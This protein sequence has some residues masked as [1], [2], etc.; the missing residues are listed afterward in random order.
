MGVSKV[1]GLPEPRPVGPN[2]TFAFRYPAPCLVQLRS[3]LWSPF[4]WA[5]IFVC[6][7]CVQGGVAA[8]QD[9]IDHTDP[10]TTAIPDFSIDS[11][12]VVG[13]SFSL[14]DRLEYGKTTSDVVHLVNKADCSVYNME[15]TA[16]GADGVNSDGA[17]CGISSS[18]TPT[19]TVRWSGNPD[20]FYTVWSAKIGSCSKEKVGT[21]TNTCTLLTDVESLG[22]KPY[23]FDVPLAVILGTARLEDGITG[24]RE[25]CSSVTPLVDS[26]NLYI[27]V[28]ESESNDVDVVTVP[29]EF[30]Y[31]YD[32]PKVP[33][34]V[35]VVA[36]G[37]TIDVSWTKLSDEEDDI[38]YQIYYS[39]QPFSDRSEVP[40]GNVVTVSGAKSSATLQD[41]E[42]G[43]EYYVSVGAKD[44]FDNLGE[45]SANAVATPI[46][47][48]DGFEAYKDAGG[49]EDGG[50]CF[51]ATAAY[52]SY[53]HP[54]VAILRDFRDTI[55][56]PSDLGAAF[57]DFYYSYGPYWAELIVDKEPLRSLARV[58]LLPWVLL[59]Y[60]TVKFGA[61][62]LCMM[63]FALSYSYRTVRRSVNHRIGVPQLYV[64][65]SRRTSR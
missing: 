56:M 58:F 4:G 50:F 25:C 1:G 46:E 18:D 42:V 64:E 23:E 30:E 38:N 3:R 7:A 33:S 32:P 52:G 62:G 6:V 26:I 20:A 17:D 60:V 43:V 39:T 53:I 41:L 61:V 13:D 22:D 5:V 59:A 36:A 19:I 16:A 40:S 55:L 8:A 45:L 57:V 37:E 29:V 44:I 21:S 34:S 48:R 14:S 2:K 49:G 35:T 9:V 31:D 63:V 27:Y 65:L 54:H 15:G 12:E 47:T 51:V 11:I 24:A 28:A 10:V